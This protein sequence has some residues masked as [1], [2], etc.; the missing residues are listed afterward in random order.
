MTRLASAVRR[1]ALRVAVRVV[2][3]LGAVGAVGC[4][5]HRPAQPTGGPPVNA[6]SHASDNGSAV[7]DL[8]LTEVPATGMSSTFAV[9]LT[10]DGGWAPADRGISKAL[11]AH[12]VP[13]VGLSS[14][15]YLASARTPEETARDLA[16]IL[17]HYSATWGRSRVAVIGYSRGADLA[18]FMV[19]RLPNDLRDRVALVALLGPSAW[20]GFQ[21]HIVDL[22]TN[23][24]RDGDLPVAPEIERL[25]G[26]TVLCI[27]GRRDRDAICPSLDAAV[28]R[29][30]PRNGGHAVGGREGAALADT[31][32]R[33]LPRA[34]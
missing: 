10:G 1:R 32:L 3:M 19:S 25:R 14:P 34:R 18:P 28:A 6:P 24:H 15:R 11:A 33:A 23:T 7:A 16:R 5:G 21:F 9:M 12:G 8:P 17:R 26:T 29:P 31:I 2:V 30:V 27:Y 13:V 20:A 22:V 4:D